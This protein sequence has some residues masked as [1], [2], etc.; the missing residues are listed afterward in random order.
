MTVIRSPTARLI[1]TKPTPQLQKFITSFLELRFEWSS[2]HW[3]RH[4]KLYHLKFSHAQIHGFDPNPS[5]CKTPCLGSKPTSDSCDTLPSKP[6]TLGLGIP[7]KLPKI[8]SL[9]WGEIL[10]SLAHFLWNLRAVPLSV[11]KVMNPIQFLWVVW[12]EVRS[13]IHPRAP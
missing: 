9:D 2:K 4:A 3:N 8:N 7:P 6:R 11:L 12:P 5:G 10:I 13:S 1:L